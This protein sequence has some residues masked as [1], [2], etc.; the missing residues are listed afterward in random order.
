MFGCLSEVCVDNASSVGT[1]ESETWVHPQGYDLVG[2][3]KVWC[4][5]SHDLSV[6]MEGYRQAKKV[7]RGSCPLGGEQLEC[8]EFC[9]DDEPRESLQGRVQGITS[10]DDTVLGSCLFAGPGP[11]GGLRPP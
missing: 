7:R 4:D 10:M 6:A 3:R 8:L 5:G 9:V 2:I 1:G 11:H